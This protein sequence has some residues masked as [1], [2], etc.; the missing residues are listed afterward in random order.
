MFLRNVKSE[1]WM[2]IGQLAINSSQNFIEWF[3]LPGMPKS[4]TV[5]MFKNSVKQ[6]LRSDISG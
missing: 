2:G 3:I 4:L 5:N 6:T 1:N